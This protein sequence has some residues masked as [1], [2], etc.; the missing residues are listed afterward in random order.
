MRHEE[1]QPEETSEKKDLESVQYYRERER[2]GSLI[3]NPRDS[4]RHCWSKL[5]LS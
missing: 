3:L 5:W 2:S 4:V 1:R